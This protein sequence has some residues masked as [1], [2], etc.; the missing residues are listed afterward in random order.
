MSKVILK[1]IFQFVIGMSALAM[2]SGVVTVEARAEAAPV[3]P[4]L[5]CDG[6]GS[7]PPPD[8]SE[9]DNIDFFKKRLLYYRC[10]DYDKDI[11]DVID[12]ARTWIASRAPQVERPAIV[13]DIDETSLLNWP[14]IYTDGYAYFP[15]FPGG[16]CDIV[17]V[18]DPCGDLDWQKRG[19]A[20]AIGPTLELYRSARCIE[21]PQPCN[22]IT[23]F[24]VTG[25][26]EKEY[27]GELPSAWTLRNLEAAGYVGVTRDRLMM[28]DPNN[29]GSA[30][31]HKI[32]ARAAIESQGF[33]IIANIGDQ[34]SDLAGGHS[35]MTFKLPNPFYFIE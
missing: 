25:R 1:A 29:T 5:G 21:Q 3:D 19:L 35:E 24:F 7:A 6:A 4:R 28:R 8:L 22:A 23:V 10:T 14:R 30:S 20:K 17:R 27:N 2:I 9:P 26:R 13:L 31:N 11:A 15:T 32:P 33:R 34:K 16:G 12:R 18:G